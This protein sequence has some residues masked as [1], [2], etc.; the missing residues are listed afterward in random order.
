MRAPG[1][2]LTPT[3]SNIDRF[4]ARRFVL[5]SVSL[6]LPKLN[7]AIL[8]LEPLHI[9]DPRRNFQLQGFAGRAATTTIHDATETGVSGVALILDIDTSSRA[10]S[11]TQRA[12]C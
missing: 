4:P 7:G 11:L 12:K 8:P 2:A 10:D 1:L 3:H 6:F 5:T 9:F